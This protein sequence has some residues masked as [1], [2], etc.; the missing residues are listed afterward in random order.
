VMKSRRLMTFASTCWALIAQVNWHPQLGFPRTPASRVPARKDRTLAPGY[1]GSMGS[2]RRRGMSSALISPSE[3]LKAL[4]TPRHATVLA[5]RF[6]PSVSAH[7]SVASAR[8][9]A[10]GHADALP[11]SAMNSRRRIQMS[12]SIFGGATSMLSACGNWLP[13]LSDYGPT[14]LFAGDTSTLSAL[15]PALYSD[16]VCGCQRS[17]WRGLRREFG[18][19]AS[20]SASNS[21][22]SRFHCNHSAETNPR[23]TTDSASQPFVTT[24][25]IRLPC[26][27][28]A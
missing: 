12:G 28:V 2:W 18:A 16:R 27:N 5:D 13:R 11:S 26:L 6:R 24:F 25:F 21:P 20:P 4:G 14:V 23:I 3:L 7:R 15:Q 22:R 1:S 9:A 19:P 10:S 17:D 8:F